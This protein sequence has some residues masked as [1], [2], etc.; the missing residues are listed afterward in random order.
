MNTDRSSA[1]H[2]RRIQARFNATYNNNIIAA[3][4]NGIPTLKHAASNPDGSLM[5][6]I[7][8]GNL[9]VSP[10]PLTTDAG[11]P[12]PPPAP[13]TAFIPTVWIDADGDLF[14]STASYGG[15]DVAYGQGTWIAVGI[16]TANTIKISSDHALTWTNKSNQMPSDGTG[17]GVYSLATDGYGKWVAVGDESN[18]LTYINTILYSSD[19]G[20]TWASNNAYD[21]GFNASNGN[22]R[23]GLGVTY[24]NGLWIAVGNY[25]TSE[26]NE[27][28]VKIATTF[29]PVNGPN[30]TNSPV[31][32]GVSPIFGSADIGLCV[33][34]GSGRWC[35]GGE[36][37]SSPPNGSIVY[38]SNGLTWTTATNTFEGSC[39]GIATDGNGNWVAVGSKLNG[40][41]KPIKYSSDNGVTWINTPASDVSLFTSGQSVTHGVRPDGVSVWVAVGNGNSQTIIY[42]I[43]NGLSWASAGSNR[44]AGTGYGVYFADDRWVAV[45]DGAASIKYSVA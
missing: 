22:T 3:N 13:P 37:N 41:T 1:T 18:L 30:W 45:G 17:K 2:T 7:K 27:R 14:T 19:N 32:T 11:P 39:N 34:Y 23:K 20:V 40:D 31:G 44:F 29:D 12:P 10:V 9:D 35:V 5:P 8:Q 26:L 6:Y 43:D 4:K 28:V 15:R 16:D 38:S 25:T 21:S 33:A 24:N 36:D 42:S